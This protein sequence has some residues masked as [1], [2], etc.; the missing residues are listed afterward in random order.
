LSAS[1]RRS[2]ISGNR[3]ANG[4]GGILSKKIATRDKDERGRSRYPSA[5]SVKI[6]LASIHLHLLLSLYR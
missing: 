1:D 2:A 5:E 3:A 6:D 4:T